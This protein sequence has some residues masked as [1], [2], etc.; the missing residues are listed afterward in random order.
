[1]EKRDTTCNVLVI[2]SNYPRFS[3]DIC[4]WFIHEISSRI[5]KKGYKV[6]ALSPHAKNSKV[7]E[8][9][10][11]VNINRFRYFFPSRFE[12]LAY[13]SGVLY[14]LKKMPFTVISIPPFVILEFLKAWGIVKKKHVNIVHSHWLLPQGVVGALIHLCT[15]IPHVATIHG[16]DVNII[17]R[18]KMLH[19]LALFIMSNTTAVTVNS[20]YTKKILESIVYGCENK[21]QIIPMGI[22]PEK[23]WTSQKIKSPKS[24]KHIL[25]VGRLIDWKGVNYLIDAMRQVLDRYPDVIL[26]VVGTGPEE[27]AL[28]SR[29]VE[30]GIEKAI[31]FTGSVSPDDLIKYYQN[32]DV[33]V[34]PSIN[35]DGRTEAL[36]VVL[37]EAMAA[38]CPVIGSDVGGIPDIISDG[39]NGFLVPERDSF[40]LADRI[41]CILSDTELQEKFR[42]NGRNKVTASFS[43]EI[44]SRQFSDVYNHL[45]EKC[46]SGGTL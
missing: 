39:E 25:Y 4:G 1:M 42:I 9:I 5:A 35:I 7:N 34:L 13:G 44:I 18:Y 12:K 10:D 28:R 33:F 19:P 22:D 24:G 26:T 37:L 2:S 17:N 38:G 23:F 36:G 3:G 32:A 43:W 31:Q 11:N 20:S 46:R 6:T 45:E 14:N 21:I 16:S 29:A 40:S 41:I 8:N 15:G 27:A 30:L